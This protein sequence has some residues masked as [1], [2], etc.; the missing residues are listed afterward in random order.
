MDLT[1]I[2]PAVFASAWKRMKLTDE[3]L[4][5]LEKLIGTRPQLGTVIQGTGGLR[6][7][8]FAPPSW[9][10]GKSGA[11]R[12][13]YVSFLLTSECYLLEIFD[14][15]EKPNLSAAD[16]ARWRRWIQGKKGEAAT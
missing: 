12:V 11:T 9:R 2:Q 15:R 3:D 7:I 13:C 8:R 6:K 1:F 10:R 5:A 4:Q 16:K 14:K